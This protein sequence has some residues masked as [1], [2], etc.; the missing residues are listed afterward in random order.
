MAK[1]ILKLFLKDR[2][3]ELLFGIKLVELITRN[4]LWRVLS[5]TPL[6]LFKTKET[7]VGETLAIFAIS[8]IVSFAIPLSVCIGFGLSVE[9]A[10][11]VYHI[12]P[13]KRITRDAF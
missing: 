1:Q 6:R 2:R 5:L 11:P 3:R 4:T 10:L 7:A 8:L 12:L 13:V 9:A